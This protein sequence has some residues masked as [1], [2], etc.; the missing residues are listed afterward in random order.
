[1]SILDEGARQMADAS[2]LANQLILL[3][4][5]VLAEVEDVQVSLRAEFRTMDKRLYGVRRSSF[6]GMMFTTAQGCLLLITRPHVRRRLQFI[7]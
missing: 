1:M 4:K 7:T 6:F 2:R 5:E 3:Q